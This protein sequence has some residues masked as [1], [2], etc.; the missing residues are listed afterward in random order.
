MRL[1]HDSRFAGHPVFGKNCR[2]PLHAPPMRRLLCVHQPGGGPMS[3]R[4][5]R[6][7][8]AGG[9]VAASVLSSGVAFAADA[10]YP[11]P[12]PTNGGGRG[13]GGRDGGGLN[14]GGGVGG[15]GTTGTGSGGAGTVT[16]SNGGEVSGGGTGTGS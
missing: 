12:P 1:R 11:Q 14:G 10:D 3:R 6:L 8:V 13:H 16:F 4:T 5:V 9:V 2:G 7:A 15:T